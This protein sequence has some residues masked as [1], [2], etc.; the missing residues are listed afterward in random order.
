MAIRARARLRPINCLQKMDSKDTL[1]RLRAAFVSLHNWVVLVD[2]AVIKEHMMIFD[3]A[4][5]K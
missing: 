5:W 4:L 3:E 1:H 2:S